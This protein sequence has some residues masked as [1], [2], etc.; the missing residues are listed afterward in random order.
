MTSKEGQI[1]SHRTAGYQVMLN[2]AIRQ[3]TT[4][5]AVSIRTKYHNHACHDAAIARSSR[6]VACI[7]RYAM[8]Y[9]FT[10]RKDQKKKKRWEEYNPLKGLHKDRRPW[11]ELHIIFQTLDRMQASLAPIESKKEQICKNVTK[12]PQGRRIE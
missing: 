12:T 1:I 10:E 11:P 8:P 4:K 3:I 7:F 2:F 9:R 5:I 6:V